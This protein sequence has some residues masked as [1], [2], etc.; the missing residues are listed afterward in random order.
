M[1]NFAVRPEV[2]EA[3]AGKVGIASRY[4]YPLN[5]NMVFV[6]VPVMIN[7]RLAGIVRTG[8]PI[9]AT[10]S[11]LLTVYEEIFAGGIVIV[12]LAA[13][14]SLCLSKDEPAHHGG[15]ERRHPICRG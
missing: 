7:G 15:E 13:I 3:M 12:L 11:N 2:V 8:T 4:S 5:V 10:N 9:S 1:D 6:A 14:I